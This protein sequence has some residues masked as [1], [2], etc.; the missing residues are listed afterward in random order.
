MT[1]IPPDTQSGK[2]IDGTRFGASGPVWVIEWPVDHRARMLYR[3]SIEPPTN[4]PSNTV[5]VLRNDS[6]ALTRAPSANTGEYEPHHKIYLP[7]SSP[8]YLVWLTSSGDSPPTA[9]LFAE[10]A[11][12]P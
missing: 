2:L 4:I 12:R 9:T 11:G 5:L 6:V 3:I 8:L 10:H 7:A 1:Q